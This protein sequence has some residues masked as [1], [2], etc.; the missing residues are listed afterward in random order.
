MTQLTLMQGLL[1]HSVERILLDDAVVQK[2]AKL[3]ENHGG[4]C[5][6]QL[7][8]KFGNSYL[9]GCANKDLWGLCAPIS[10]IVV[11]YSITATS[12]F[13]GDKK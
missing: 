1:D 2:I 5:R 8:F 12:Y 10:I 4:R 11:Y 13:W 6:L 7:Y 3:Q 9:L